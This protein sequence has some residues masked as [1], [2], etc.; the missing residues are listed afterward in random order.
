MIL[1]INFINLL[2][3]V[4]TSDKHKFSDVNENKVYK[5]SA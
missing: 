1:N 5:E 2:N 3:A 4:I